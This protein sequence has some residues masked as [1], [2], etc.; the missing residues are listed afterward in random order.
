MSDRTTNHAARRVFV[1]DVASPRLSRRWDAAFTR[2]RGDQR[3]ERGVHERCQL[4]GESSTLK[5]RE[6]YVEAKNGRL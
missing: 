4:T 6:R 3:W 5:E 1:T 2:S